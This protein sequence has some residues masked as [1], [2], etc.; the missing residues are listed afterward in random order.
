M[1]TT[2]QGFPEQPTDASVVLRSE[3]HTWL[4]LDHDTNGELIFG[5]TNGHAKTRYIDCTINECGSDVHIE[6]ISLQRPCQNFLAL[7][8]CEMHA[9]SV[10]TQFPM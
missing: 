3:E 5:K 1:P 9:I 4:P 6:K 2:L 7:S 8:C 10:N